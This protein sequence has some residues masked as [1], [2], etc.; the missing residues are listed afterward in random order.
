MWVTEL[1]DSAFFKMTDYTVMTAPKSWTLSDCKVYENCCVVEEALS[2]LRDDQPVG[3]M[4]RTFA[5][6]RVPYWMQPCFLT[7]R[8][9]LPERPARDGARDPRRHY[10][11]ISALLHDTEMPLETG[12]QV[13]IETWN[14]CT[15]ACY[16]AFCAELET[17]KF[18]KGDDRGVVIYQFI[19]ASSMPE[20][21]QEMM[22]LAPTMS[23]VRRG[24]ELFEMFTERI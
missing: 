5:R 17:L 20:W 21:M 19:M 10:A 9:I 12:V 2:M 15:W 11:V 1:G 8:G 13:C 14:A 23:H 6:L 7:E 18:A 4:D 22:C 24:S 3:M 16:N